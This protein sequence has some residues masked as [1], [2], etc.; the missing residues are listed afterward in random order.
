MA[1]IQDRYFIPTLYPSLSAPPPAP[2]LRPVQT[3]L[4]EYKALQKRI[5]KDK[6]LTKILIQDVDAV[7]R[8]MERWFGEAKVVAL[9]AGGGDILGA[10]TGRNRRDDDIEEDE[11]IEE[12]SQE[13]WA[14]ERLSEALC[15][16]GVLVPISKK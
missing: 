9:A 14:L 6:S 7:Y 12:D 2:H 4:Q 1:W 3:I 5:V 13:V 10:E 11:N 16:R 15:E 8:D